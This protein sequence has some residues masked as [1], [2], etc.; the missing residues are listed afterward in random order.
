M[1][2]VLKIFI[3]GDHHAVWNAWNNPKDITH[4]YQGHV[5]WKT[6]EATNLL[7]VGEILVMSWSIKIKR[8]LLH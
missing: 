3:Q 2:I 5:D 4:W 7:K 8:A 6:T 1:M